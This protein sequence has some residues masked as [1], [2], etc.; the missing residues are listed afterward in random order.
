MGHAA[1]LIVASYLAN[2]ILV[3]AQLLVPHCRLDEISGVVRAPLEHHNAGSLSEVG[4]VLHQEPG[5]QA[6]PFLSG[7]ECESLVLAAEA[8]AADHGWHSDR[9][10]K[11]ATTDLDVRT[12]PELWKL[13]QPH[14]QEIQGRARRSMTLVQP[15]APSDQDLVFHDIFLVRYA[16]DGQ[17]SLDSHEDGSLVTF[18]VALSAEGSDFEGGGTFFEDLGCRFQ[19]SL[20]H[21]VV[22]PG[23]LRHR[24]LA[25]TRGRRHVLVGFSRRPAAGEDEHPRLPLGPPL[26]VVHAPCVGPAEE[27][28]PLAAAVEWRGCPEERPTVRAHARAAAADGAARWFWLERGNTSCRDER[29]ALQRRELRL[30][31]G[32]AVSGGGFFLALPPGHEY[33]AYALRPCRAPDPFTALL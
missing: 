15:Q 20:G 19:P 14:L 12:V 2:V 22:F 4:Q 1:C 6:F 3:R 9:H 18:Q 16:L 26:R 30:R 11:Y 8:F 28:W 25:I 23:G 17:R 5:V 31:F 10:K 24:G 33:S 13:V 21:A 27:G 32:F 29:R 7:E